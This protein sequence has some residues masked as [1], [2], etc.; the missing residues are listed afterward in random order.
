MAD[1]TMCS[2]ENCPFKE[3]CKRFKNFPSERQAY[4][5]N[6]PFNGRECKQFLSMNGDHT[7]KFLPFE[8]MDYE[9]KNDKYSA[10]P[11]TA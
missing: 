10:N 3:E 1:I 7:K 9:K 8:F 4:F 6:T 11:K 5:M 2:G